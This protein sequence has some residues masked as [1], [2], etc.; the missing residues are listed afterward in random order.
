[1][2]FDEKSQGDSR[3]RELVKIVKP[4]SPSFQMKFKD[5]KPVQ[6]SGAKESAPAPKIRFYTSV[7]VSVQFLFFSIFLK[8][9]SK[10]TLESLEF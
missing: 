6:F 5:S 8:L 7:L 3:N 2:V 1:M 4:S 10:H 9:F